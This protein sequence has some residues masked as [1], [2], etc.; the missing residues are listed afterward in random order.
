MLRV[1]L[2]TL[3]L[4][5]SLQTQAA[6]PNGSHFKKVLF[7]IFENTDYAAALKQPYFQQLT[8]QGALL[9][10]MTGMVHPSQGNYIS[11]LA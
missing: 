8:T 3:A 6:S 2:V 4:L 10:N 5:L 7:I 1:S 11:L 9:Q